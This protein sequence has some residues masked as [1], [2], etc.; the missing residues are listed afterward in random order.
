MKG[1]SV[2]MSVYKGEK[3]NYLDECF[4][5]LHEQTIKAN[6]IILVIDG[7]VSK[8]LYQVIDKW[9]EILPIIKVK[10]DKNVGLGQALNIG[11]K[12]CNF[13]LVARMDTDD[14]CVKDRFSLQ[15]KFFEE[16]NDIMVLGGEIEEYD[17]S[18]S[19]PL[20]KRTTALSHEEI[21]EVAKKRNPLN[22][23]TVMYKKVLS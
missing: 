21:I 13:E 20:G 1:F 5:S 16:N 2:L 17:Q 14:Y 23:M 3:E 8:E 7:P 9:G 11:L 22:H 6:E 15:M 10:L 12:H 19:I 18:L 4:K